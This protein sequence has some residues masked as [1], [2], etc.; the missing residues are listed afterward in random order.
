MR[1]SAS[2]G[3]PVALTTP[4]EGETDH[5]W[6]AMLPDG[7]AVV[8]AAGTTGSWNEASLIV[9]PLDGGPRTVLL[10]GGTAPQYVSSGHI[11]YIRSGTIYAVPVDARGSMRGT[12]RP[13]VENVAF[14]DSDGRA[15][16][17][18][19]ATGTL[20]YIGGFA[21]SPNRSLAWVDRAGRVQPLPIG[22]RAYEQP[23]ISPDGRHVALTIRAS[24]PDVW[25]LDLARS[26][27]SRFTFDSGEDESPIWTADSRF[28]T[29]GSSR[30][31]QD[32]QTF[33]KPIDGSTGE[34]VVLSGVR[35]QH[36][37]SWSPDGKTLLTEEIDTNWRLYA[38]DRESRKA[39]PL[40]SKEFAALG[41][42]LS[43]DGRWVAYSSNE[44]GATEIYVQ[45]FPGP[46]SK[47]QVSNGGGSEPRWSPKGDEL[48]YRTGDRMMAV[49]V[50]L[51]PTFVADTPH[52]LF[53]GHFTRMGWGQSNYDVA[54]DGKRFLMVQGNDPPLPGAF[55]LV[56][57]W[58]EELKPQGAAAR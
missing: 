24:N 30:G 20:L 5:R 32:R 53:E 15:H 9:Q 54:A 39:S 25:L 36:L 18:V 47:S 3:Q 23:R 19:S 1:V 38:V 51:Q 45:A 41:G 7:R 22:E 48:F 12:P 58:F 4:P 52:M 21:V 8:Y 57:N 6:P 43:P 16:Y 37:G 10:R 27:L 46:G 49:K 28:I 40:T 34:Q 56:A 11:V 42:Q 29:F 14:N 26:T 44:G 55:K 17:I 13:L 50:R 35:H 2:G 31:G 33:W